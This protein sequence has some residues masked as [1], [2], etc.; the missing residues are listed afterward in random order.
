[1]QTSSD[2]RFVSPTVPNRTANRN[3]GPCCTL[4]RIRPLHRFNEHTDERQVIAVVIEQ[5]QPQHSAIQN[6][7]HNTAGGS[8]KRLLPIPE[9]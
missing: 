2:D 1:M 3:G 6:E 8:T 4:G 5:P 7:G 9:I